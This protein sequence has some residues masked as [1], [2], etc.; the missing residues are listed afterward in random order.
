[1]KI[2]QILRS[3]YAIIERATRGCLGSVLSELYARSIITETVRDS[4]SYSKAMGEF[5]SKFSLISDMSQLKSH[6]LEFL[7]CIS[8]GGPT[9][10]VVKKLAAE[11][12]KELDMEFL[13]TLPAF[14]PSPSPTS[15]PASKGIIIIINLIFT[16]IVIMHVETTEIVLKPFLKKT[17]ERKVHK[18]LDELRARFPGLVT[19]FKSAF[20][21]KAAKNG[22]LATDASEWLKEYMTWSDDK[23]DNTLTDV[24]NKMRPYYDFL[25]CTLLL[26]MSKV[27]LQDVTFSDNGTIRN[28]SEAIQSHSLKAKALR[29]STTISTFRKV[30]QQKFEPFDNDLDN[31]P[32][33]RIHLETVWEGRSIDA[34]YKL[35]EKL[36]PEKFRQSLT[37]HISIYPGSVVIKLTVLDSTADSLKEYAEGKLQFMHLVGIFSLYINNYA[38]LQEDENMNFTFD[39]ALL[40]AVTADHNE[41]VKFLLQLETVNIDHTNEE[42]T[43][44]LMLASERGYEDI[45]H[46]L[47]SA[48]SNVNL[49]DNNGWTALMKASEHNHI[50]IINMLLQANANPHLKKSNGS[51]ALMIA[52][53]NGSCAVAELLINKG[54]DYKYQR[55]DGWNAFMLACQNGHTEIVKLLLKEQVDPNAQDKDGWNA[56]M[57]ACSI[58]HT[59]I[60]KLLLKEQIDRNVQDKDGMNAFMLACQKGHTQIVELLL[61]EKVDPTVKNKDG[62]NA[63]ILACATGHTQIVELLLKA[64]VDP[65]VKNKDGTSAFMLACATGHTQMV[66]LLLKEQVNPN[67]QDN[68]GM[69]AFMLV[70]FIGYTQI[71]ELLLKKQV[72]PNLQNKNGWNA[73]MLACQKGHTQIVELLL[74]A[75]VDPTVQDNN[76]MNA[77]MLACATGHIQIVALLL[78][79]QVDPNVKNKDGANA[80]MLAC[81]TGHIQ[82]VELLLKEQVDLNIKNKDGWNAFMLACATGHIQIVELLLKELVDPTVKNKD[83]WNAF[84]LACQNGHTQIVELLLKAQVDPNVPN[85]NGWNAFM[86]A[87]QN[88]HIQIVE[89][90][91]KEKVD[92][93]VQDNNGV[94]AFMFTCQNGHAEIVK[95]LLNIINLNAT[96]KDGLTA[97]MS[98]CNAKAGNSEIVQLLL[99]AGADPN[100]QCK[101]PN[102]P[103]LNGT[104]ALMFASINGHAQAV[105]YLLEAGSNPNVQSEE[106]GHTAL[107]LASIEGYAQIVQLLLKAG[108]NPNLTTKKVI[109][110]ALS[111]AV[112]VNQPVIVSELLKAGASTDSVSL[113]IRGTTIELTVIQLCMCTL[114]QNVDYNAQ[115]I[116]K[117]VKEVLGNDANFDEHYEK[118]MQF[119]SGLNIKDAIEILHLLLEAKPQP[120]DDPL[121]L[122]IGSHS[123]SAKA[124]DMLLKAG[125]NPLQHLSSQA[126][127]SLDPT[128]QV[129]EDFKIFCPS[130]TFACVKGN[131]E[132]VEVLLKA[133][134]DPNIQQENGET[135]LMIACECGQVDIA[136]TLLENGADPNICDNKGN[137]ALHAVL[138]SKMNEESKLSIT[139]TLTSRNI[140]VNTQNANGITPLVVASIKGHTEVILLLLSDADPNITDN[141]GTTALMYACANGHY[142]VAA[143]LL[144]AYNADPSLTDNNGSTA[145]CYAAKGGQNEVI[146]VL[147]RNYDY[148]QEEIERALTTACYGGHKAVIKEL[149]KKANFTEYQKEIIT[150]CVSND[151]AFEASGFLTLP[152][153]ESTGLTPLMLASSCSSISVVQKL[154]ESGADVNK[155]DNYLQYSPLLY[156]VSGSKSYAMVQYLLDHGANVNIISTESQAPLDIAKHYKLDD[157]A[158]LLESKNGKVYSSLTKVAVEEVDQVYVLLSTAQIV[159]NIIQALCYKMMLVTVVNRFSPSQTHPFAHLIS[160]TVR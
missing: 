145:L 160:N 55:E 46:S 44:A 77:F 7:E 35:I 30:L 128:L 2:K 102:V 85:K 141:K 56:F 16:F 20:R 3:H 80:F 139:Q 28:L 110:T 26:D 31:I 81:A 143:L 89:L 136:Q 39:L 121:T 9:H 42:G 88:G 10:D 22:Q 33:I 133:I 109:F 114:M 152:L 132:V 118:M 87:C 74:K 130:L 123:G 107:I 153:I 117:K 83:G 60:V 86:A 49:Q 54:V 29:A 151:V 64:Q 144:M 125:Y 90:L 15:P 140:N 24:F 48:G 5:E 65:N 115:Q 101:S 146:N 41:A 137:N 58:G 93:N 134:G 156:A 76:G 84:M 75:Q 122:I 69:N 155:Q 27:F 97:L 119:H 38:V 71:I 154:V 52:S 150:A 57:L 66:E 91:L 78:K 67:V 1:M 32:F 4:Q 70:C 157:V 108:A 113:V 68:N 37:D 131:L 14:T 116:R 8:Q 18:S 63:F 111:A 59:Q 99:N 129:K 21:E 47:L 53:F 148:N 79:E 126:I 40:K 105:Q 159:N 50:S 62:A 142:E 158:K 149:A 103:S 36:L 51:N 104:T 106:L 72:D 96:N 124:V 43:T 82:I 95:L 138:L 92:P 94:N 98:A 135:M 45:V 147:I 112:I 19:T 12:G 120:Q 100:V 25:D 23:V 34:L 61:K 13:L 17:D 6:C 127:S 11:W 73:F